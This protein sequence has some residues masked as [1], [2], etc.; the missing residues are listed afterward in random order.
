[1]NYD[2][3]KRL[4]S[5]WLL[6]TLKRYE[7]P[8][9]MDDNAMRQ[10]M[11][12]M[13][14]DINS[15]IPTGAN[16]GGIKYILSKSAEHVRKNQTSRRWPPISL[17]VKGVKE[18]RGSM[19]EDHLAITH[20]PKD[21][22]ESHVMARKIKRG[23]PVGDWWITGSGRQMVLETGLVDVSDFEPYEKYLRYNS[24]SLQ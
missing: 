21:F 8:T 23:D 14:E 2:E 17:F 20:Q 3:R 4:I 19:V 22:D 10:E 15:E 16:E 11:V 12:L 6:E 24:Q 18:N 9:H 1:M 7:A 5:G 13:V